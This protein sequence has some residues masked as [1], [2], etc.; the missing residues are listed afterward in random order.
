[1][2]GEIGAA[3]TRLAKE[4][5]EYVPKI[6]SG[7]LS[8]L[9]VRSGENAIRRTSPMGSVLVD[10]VKSYQDGW[11]KMA[12]QDYVEKLNS[13]K[14]FLKHKEITHDFATHW[15]NYQNLPSGPLKDA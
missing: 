12:G 9:G 15:Q 3:V 2:G 5:W 8:N 7:E 6:F 4:A 10:S 13:L 1:M 14:P 11:A